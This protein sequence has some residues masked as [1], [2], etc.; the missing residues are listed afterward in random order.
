MKIKSLRH[1]VIPSS[2]SIALLHLFLLLS[3][4]VSSAADIFEVKTVAL[5]F[6]GGN[7]ITLAG[8][9]DSL[10]AKLTVTY[11]N[12]GLLEGRWLLAEP[13]STEQ[14]IYRTL[15]LVRH[16]LNSSQRSFLESPALP[17]NRVGKYLL[18][19][20][21]SN[22]TPVEGRIDSNSSCPN[23]S[24]VAQAFYQV[25]ESVTEVLPVEK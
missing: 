8:L 22:R 18:Q 9:N 1:S 2:F 20:C 12:I 6:E 10:Q 7:N 21:V 15:K 17:T 16:N 5:E 19:F 14:P 24:L 3:I 11:N 25:Y 13:G 4:S 23:G